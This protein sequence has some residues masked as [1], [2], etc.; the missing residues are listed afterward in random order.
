[1][2]RKETTGLNTIEIPLTSPDIPIASC[3]GF[4]MAIRF[5]T[6][7]PKIRVKYDRTRVITITAAASKV[8]LGIFTPRERIQSTKGSE[9]LSAAKALPRKPER[10]IATWIVARNLAGSLVK[11]NNLFA[12]LFP[13][14]AIRSSFV[15]LIDNTA[16]SALAKTAFKKIN[17]ACNNN[18]NIKELFI[19]LN[20]FQNKIFF[21]IVYIQHK[22]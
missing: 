10:V 22:T 21:M 7:S 12:L 11:R 15:S 20:L 3:S 19:C 9:K 4:F 6:N 18:K 1:M 8:A 14:C 2:E 17:T 16:I 5:G 13:S